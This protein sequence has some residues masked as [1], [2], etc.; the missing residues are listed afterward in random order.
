MDSIPYRLG[1]IFVGLLSGYLIVIAFLYGQLKFGFIEK[2]GGSESFIIA[3]LFIIFIPLTLSLY[4]KVNSYK[5]YFEQR[6][7]IYYYG[8]GIVGLPLLSLIFGT[9][10]VFG[11]PIFL[12][13]FFAGV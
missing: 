8:F 2:Q 5:E 7:N 4:L 1:Q 9:Q 6:I 11:L 10:V 3:I 13:F 12:F